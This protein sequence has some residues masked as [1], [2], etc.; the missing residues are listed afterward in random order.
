MTKVTG[1]SRTIL[2][3]RK[4]IMNT[5]IRDLRTEWNKISWPTKKTVAKKTA[6]V[7]TASVIMAGG[8][9]VVDYIF[10][11]LIGVFL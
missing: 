3:E 4:K 6:V 5:K 1:V 10:Q 8:I 9:A 11:S 7:L 2:I